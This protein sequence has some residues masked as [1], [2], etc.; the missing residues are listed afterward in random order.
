V[1]D[2]RADFRLIAATNRDL[3]AEVGAG[4]FRSDLYFRLNVVRI[5]MPPLRERLEDL[6]I[7][8]DAVLRPLSKDL[9]RP[10]PRIS[11]RALDKLKTYGWPGNVRE[12]RNVLERAMLTLPG[13]EIRT[14]DLTI[15]GG[16]A[17]AAAGNSGALPQQEWEIQPL[18]DVVAS[19]VAAAV[20]A[21]DGNMRKAARLLNISPSTLYARLKSAKPE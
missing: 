9:G 2:L 8:V 18:D 5:R 6:P 20:K 19:Y 1:R 12:L 15:E 3:T 17:V 7:L 13:D 10:M 21:V 11:P 16:G 14:E 4:R